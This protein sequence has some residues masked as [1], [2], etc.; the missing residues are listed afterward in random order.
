[1]CRY[2]R[3]APDFWR[4]MGMREFYAWVDETARQTNAVKADDPNSWEGT[5][6]D[7]WWQEA[8]RKR[9]ELLEST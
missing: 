7:E 1:M 9:S 5:E 8:R 4:S 3:W 2:W 6:H